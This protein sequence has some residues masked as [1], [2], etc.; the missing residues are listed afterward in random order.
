MVIGLFKAEKI[1]KVKN[2]PY[3]GDYEAKTEMSKTFTNEKYD[4]LVPPKHG[5][6]ISINGIVS[7]HKVTFTIGKYFITGEPADEA[8]E[9]TTFSATFTFEGWVYELT[10]NVNGEFVSLDEWHCLAS[11]E[12]GDEP[13]YRYTEDSK[14]IEW[15][16]LDM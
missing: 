9:Q 16:L 4:G 14:D 10:V 3:Y 5:I 12:D 13:D 7:D 8:N 15:Y 11:F 1:I 2:N 6:K